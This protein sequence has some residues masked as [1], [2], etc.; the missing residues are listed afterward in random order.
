M[1]IGM[2]MQDLLV[3]HEKALHEF[4]RRPSLGPDGGIRRDYVAISGHLAR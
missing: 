2:D 4:V 3:N 1:T